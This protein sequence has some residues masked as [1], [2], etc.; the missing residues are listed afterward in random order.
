[1]GSIDTH[2]AYVTPFGHTGFYVELPTYPDALR[3]QAEM[4]ALSRDYLIAQLLK[5]ANGSD[6]LYKGAHQRGLSG[7]FNTGDILAAALMQ[8]GEP[9]LESTSYARSVE[10]RKSAN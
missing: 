3:F 10:K 5:D 1:M 9:F 7:G 2:I 4:L 6:V 8:L